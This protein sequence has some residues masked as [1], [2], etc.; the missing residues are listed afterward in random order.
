[1]K[2][3]AEKC[4]RDRDRVWK[5]ARPGEGGTFSSRRFSPIIFGDTDI[6]ALQ[7]DN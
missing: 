3:N 7:A 2:K 5:N 6:A 1:M 4:L